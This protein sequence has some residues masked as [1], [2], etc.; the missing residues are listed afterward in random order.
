MHSNR[1]DSIIAERVLVAI[2]D[3]QETSVRVIIGH[4]QASPSGSAY[5]CPFQIAGIGSECIKHA[6]GV[7]A[8]Q[9]LQLV[10]K[11]IGAD[12]ACAGDMIKWPLSEDGEVGFKS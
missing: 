6:A 3:G 5:L 1:I 11:M 2:V 8:V 4:P 12:L 7:D 9:S 10:I